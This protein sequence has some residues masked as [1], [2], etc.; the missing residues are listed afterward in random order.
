MLLTYVVCLRSTDAKVDKFFRLAQGCLLKIGSLCQE[1]NYLG[2]GCYFFVLIPYRQARCS[3]FIWISSRKEVG[4]T[5]SRSGPKVRI[6][7]INSPLGSKS[8]VIKPY[9]YLSSSCDVYGL[10]SEK[11]LWKGFVTIKPC[12]YDDRVL[13]TICWIF[14]SGSWVTPTISLN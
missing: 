14:P 12:M 8:Y 2:D 3:T 9:G 1:P 6:L 7:P 13:M 10:S 5:T 11:D 4:I